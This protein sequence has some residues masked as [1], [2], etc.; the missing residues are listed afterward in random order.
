MINKQESKIHKQ[1]DRDELPLRGIPSRER[2]KGMRIKRDEPEKVGVTERNQPERIERY[3][4]AYDWDGRTVL[5]PI[6][7]KR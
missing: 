5:V 4:R 1:V 7:E 6:R 2:N 3:E